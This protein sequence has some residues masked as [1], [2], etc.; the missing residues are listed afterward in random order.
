VGGGEEGITAKTPD[1]ELGGQ[2]YKEKKESA[3]G[4]QIHYFEIVFFEI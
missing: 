4:P 3:F 1:A 2:E